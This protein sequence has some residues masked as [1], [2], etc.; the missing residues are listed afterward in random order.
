MKT[1]TKAIIA[2]SAL[3]AVAGCAKEQT[4]DSAISNIERTIPLSL[5]AGQEDENAN[6]RAAVDANNSKVIDW[7]KDDCLSVFD[8]ANANCKFTLDDA[9]AGKSVGT[10]SG[11]VSKTSAAGYA[12]LYPYQSTASY[13][14]SKIN[15]VVLKSAQT[16]VSGSFDPE[17]AL[18]CAKST[19]AGE[20]LSFWNIV[21]FLKFTTDFE[22]KEVTLVSNNSSDKLA[23]TIEVNPSDTTFSVTSG[24]ASQITLSPASGNL[25]A[26]TYYIA[27]LP[28]TLSKGFKLIFTMTD[29]S[30]KY[31]SS[32]KSW[33]FPRKKVKNITTAF[34][35]DA[36]TT[37][38]S[39][40]E[41]ANCYLVKTAGS[42]AFKAV[43]GNSATSVG[44]VSSVEVLW[45]SDGS[46]SAPSKGAIVAS[47]ATFS[48]D[49]I[50]FSIPVQEVLRNGNA[51]IAA[52]DAGGTI[53]WSWHIWCTSEGYNEQVYNNNAGTMMDRNLGAITAEAGNVGSLG[54]LYQW[55]RKDPFLGSSSVSS[56]TKAASTSSAWAT[57]S[58][59][60]SLELTV[61]NPMTFYTGGGMPDGSWASTKTV[62]D[63]CPAGWRVPDGGT[64]GIWATAKG[65]SSD[66][67]VTSSSYGLNFS[68]AFGGDAT[69]WYPAAGYYNASGTFEATGSYGN[70]WSATYTSNDAYDLN[71]ATRNE[72]GVGYVCP[73][74]KSGSRAWGMSVRCCKIK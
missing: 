39:A 46:E 10:F 30:Q 34:S 53:L 52:K 61:K 29:G 25:A 65:S 37:D 4:N 26:G 59:S 62:N 55:G 7:S 5:T 16:A 2:L 11:K 50:E 15:G 9:S 64:S 36:L 20:S 6:T 73:M 74:A 58:S 8:G 31:K 49:Y 23:G 32:V 42:Y 51:V 17:A 35:S 12:A 22:C 3:A 47:S 72:D 60:L 69:I 24:A 44:S 27:I 56:S 48:G 33:K 70:Y 40:S 68:G 38:L 43:K 67:R 13:D 54:L 18:M 57:S 45:E 41:S 66:F 28:G 63:P 21:G 19:K 71:F 1:F 14:G